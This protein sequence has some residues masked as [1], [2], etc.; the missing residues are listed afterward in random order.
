MRFKAGEYSSFSDSGVVSAGG[1]LFFATF[2]TPP[3]GDESA[4]IPIPVGRRPMA[5]DAGPRI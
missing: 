5:D 2:T 3:P 1:K 4:S